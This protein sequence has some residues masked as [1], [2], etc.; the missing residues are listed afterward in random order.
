MTYLI[1][2]NVRDRKICMVID[3]EIARKRACV[4]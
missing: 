2:N 3:S 1:G 4:V